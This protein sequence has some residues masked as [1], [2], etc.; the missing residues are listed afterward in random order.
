[1]AISYIILD[2]NCEELVSV[3]KITLIV[4]ISV[5]L[6]STDAS[7]IR[8][9]AP[10]RTREISEKELEAKEARRQVTNTDDLLLLS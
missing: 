5:Q 4:P 7:Q 3:I 1:M 6:A 8:E 9:D 10:K 2:V